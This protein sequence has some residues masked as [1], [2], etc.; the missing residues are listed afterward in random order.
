MIFDVRFQGKYV[1]T[2]IR[3]RGRGRGRE[4]MEEKRDKYGRKRRARK[5][6]A[7]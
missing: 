6:A 2:R 3:W 1:S 5:N 4:R 7:F